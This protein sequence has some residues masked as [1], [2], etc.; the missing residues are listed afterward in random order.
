MRVTKPSIIAEK[1]SKVCPHLTPKYSQSN[2]W[3]ISVKIQLFNITTS[4]KQNKAPITIKPIAISTIKLLPQLPRNLFKLITRIFAL[5][6]NPINRQRIERIF[7]LGFTWSW[8]GE[9]GVCLLQ[10]C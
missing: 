10:S 3:T 9:N 5:L 1:L 6:S 7:T 4:T 8:F 2:Q